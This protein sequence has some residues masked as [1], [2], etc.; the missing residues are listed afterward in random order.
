MGGWDAQV[1]LSIE[2]GSD[3]IRGTVAIGSAQPRGFQGWIELV[4]L[5]ESVRR[6]RPPETLGWSP[7][8][9]AGPV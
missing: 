7:G 9:K 4:E 2:V 8:A 3:P 5:L 1:K 6:V